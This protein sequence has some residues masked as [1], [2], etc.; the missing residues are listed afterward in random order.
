M[1]TGMGSM[2]CVM[3]SRP[4]ADALVFKLLSF[5]KRNESY[6]HIS[7]LKFSFV[8]CFLFSHIVPF[9]L[10]PIFWFC[11]FVFVLYRHTFSVVS[12]GSVLTTLSV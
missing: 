9:T 12:I 4:D 8:T 3:H 11:L 7:V 2:L 10:L 1:R 5:Y 6:L